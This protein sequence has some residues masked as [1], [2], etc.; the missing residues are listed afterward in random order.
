MRASRAT[1]GLPVPEPFLIDVPRLW[2]ATVPASESAKVQRSSPVAFGSRAVTGQLS[3]WSPG[4]SIS[5]T[6]LPMAAGIFV[7]DGI[8]QNPDRRSVNPNCLVRGDE[9]EGPAKPGP[10]SFG[11][12]PRPIEIV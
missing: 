7:F 8:I 10:F 1:F 9:R 4:N 2:A 12:V 3:V 11:A 5:D 6:M